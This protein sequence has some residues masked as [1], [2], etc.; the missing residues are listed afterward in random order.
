MYWEFFYL[1]VWEC[2]LIRNTLS[3]SQRIWPE[4]VWVMQGILGD[5]VRRSIIIC[6]NMVA[7][8]TCWGGLK[9]W[10]WLRHDRIPPRRA[11]SGSQRPGSVKGQGCHEPVSRSAPHALIH[12]GK[13]LA[14]CLSELFSAHGMNRAQ[15]VWFSAQKVSRIYRPLGWPGDDNL[16][17]GLP[18]PLTSPGNCSKPEMWI[19]VCGHSRDLPRAQ[20]TK[21]MLKEDFSQFKCCRELG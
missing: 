17:S 13:E 14:E 9:W 7:L 19:G 3:V 5:V 8:L 1:G 6:F 20:S 15:S 18:S 21:C 12:T 16:M 11:Y 2:V 4:D 10:S